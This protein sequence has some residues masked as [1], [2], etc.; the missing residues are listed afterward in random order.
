MRR[1]CG[2]NGVPCNITILAYMLT[3]TV[4]VCPAVGHTQHSGFLCPHAGKTQHLSLLIALLQ[5][6]EKQKIV[7]ENAQLC[8]SLSLLL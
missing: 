5:E 3:L 1:G 4:L 6:K 7:L 8:L 2:H